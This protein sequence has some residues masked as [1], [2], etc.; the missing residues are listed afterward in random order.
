MKKNKNVALFI[1]LIVLIAVI[2]GF[3]YGIN[4]NIDATNFLESLNT[5]NNLFLHHSLLIVIILISTLA[6]INMVSETVIF[7]IEG[8][9]SGFLIGV[10]F[11]SYKLNGLFMGILVTIVN[12]LI[13]LIL[14]SYLFMISIN[15]IKKI[16]KNLLGI[17]ND[18]IRVLIKPLLKRFALILVISLINDTIIYFFGNMLLKNFVNML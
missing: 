15:Y 17:K 12:K 5:H 4:R 10:L 14:I 1:G 16:I 13:F 8:L 3:I 7:S 9:T 2:T 11:K 18:Y 6:L